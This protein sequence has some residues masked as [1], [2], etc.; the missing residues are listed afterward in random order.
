MYSP[1]TLQ[2]YVEYPHK[3]HFLCLYACVIHQMAK[4]YEISTK[5]LTWSSAPYMGTQQDDQSTSSPHILVHG[6]H[7]QLLIWVE[8]SRMPMSSIRIYQD[9][10]S[11]R[12]LQSQ[13][14]LIQIH[15]WQV[16][17]CQYGAPA[18]DDHHHHHHH[19]HQCS[20]HHCVYVLHT[21]L[22][23]WNTWRGGFHHKCVV[24]TSF[25]I[26]VKE[27]AARLAAFSQLCV[28]A[29]TIP[30][31]NM[32]YIVS[33]WY[34]QDC[35]INASHEWLKTIHAYEYE[36]VSFLFHMFQS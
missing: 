32:Q 13:M 5:S 11:Q 2:S 16:E 8:C 1:D 29:F 28:W 6:I 33:P 18:L 23:T 7:H 27:E 22:W 17:T 30:C 21:I 15:L 9:G 31:K 36:N 14:V 26:K 25:L 12:Y 35:H 20:S 3:Y 10:V 24:S 4:S 34:H 19:H